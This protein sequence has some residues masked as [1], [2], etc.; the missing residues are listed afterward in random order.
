MATKPFTPHAGKPFHVTDTAQTNGQF[1][2]PGRMPQIGGAHGLH[3]AGA[4][5]RN[6]L[7]VK[8]PGS[9]RGR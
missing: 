8:K 1:E 4:P 6:K 3:V 9:G 7:A 2:H 5:R